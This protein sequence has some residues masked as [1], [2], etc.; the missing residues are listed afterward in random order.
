MCEL[1]HSLSKL[2][3]WQ[4]RAL[5]QSLGVE[6]R[7]GKHAVTQRVMDVHEDDADAVIEALGAVR[8]PVVGQKRR[9]P[10]KKKAVRDLTDVFE[11]AADKPAAVQHPPEP[12]APA[13]S[14]AAVTPA[15]QP[16]AAVAS[17]AVVVDGSPPMI[18]LP[19]RMRLCSP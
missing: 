9:R 18:Y 2:Y 5:A 14:P 17:H 3:Y 12:L 7:G 1:Q 6:W 13:P 10:T 8:E 16:A 11:R 4:L 15:P 19:V